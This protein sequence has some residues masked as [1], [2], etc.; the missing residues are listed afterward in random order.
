M[1]GQP[2]EEPHAEPEGGL[3]NV[4]A[5]RSKVLTNK[6]FSIRSSL[7]DEINAIWDSARE[8]E[9]GL[10]AGQKKFIENLF[11]KQDK[12]WVV[13]YDK[14]FFKVRKERYCEL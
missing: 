5:T 14:P 9:G 7:P 11:D 4:A 10:R 1:A 12:R 8:D 2:P 13:N 6:Y 3:A